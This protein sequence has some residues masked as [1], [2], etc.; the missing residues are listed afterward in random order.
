MCASDSPWTP[1][2]LPSSPGERLTGDE[3]GPLF[4]CVRQLHN[5]LGTTLNET[6]RGF[7]NSWKCCPRYE[8]DG[9]LKPGANIP[10]IRLGLWICWLFIHESA[11]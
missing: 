7:Q 10:V 8:T 9:L 2:R 3:S 4:R 11:S 1:A 6:E 5:P